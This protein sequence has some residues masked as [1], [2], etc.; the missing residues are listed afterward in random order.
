MRNINFLKG[1]FWFEMIE[2]NWDIHLGVGDKVLLKNY[3]EDL[4]SRGCN[5]LEDLDSHIKTYLISM[6]YATKKLTDLAEKQNENDKGLAD[7][8]WKRFK[9]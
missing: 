3:I 5:A 9:G 7:Y 8:V 1:K 6:G 2:I 4:T